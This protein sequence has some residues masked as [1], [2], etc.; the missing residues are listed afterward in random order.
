MAA[1]PAARANLFD[2][3]A[4]AARPGEFRACAGAAGRLDPG[5]ARPSEHA[6]PAG[7]AACGRQTLL[8]TLEREVREETGWT[9]REARLL[10]LLHF[11][12]LTP[13]PAEYRYPDFLHLVCTAT[14]DHYDAGLRELDG[15]ELESG[16][17][18]LTT[19]AALPISQ[20]E[21]IFLC[22]VAQMAGVRNSSVNPTAEGGYAP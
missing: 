5:R 15:Y 16:F 10:G 3:H 1:S 21:H 11:Q 8:Q 14:A 12:H 7:R 13:R 9:I 19:V 18:P 6:Y 2:D 17:Q 20:G 22:A 4:A